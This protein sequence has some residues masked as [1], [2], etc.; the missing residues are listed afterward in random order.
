MAAAPNIAALVITLLR[1]IPLC[2]FLMGDNLGGGVV[3]VGGGN[4]QPSIY[5]ISTPAGLYSSYTSG[6]LSSVP[7]GSTSW[8]HLVLRA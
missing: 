1:S 5:T 2:K 8:G 4:H 7:I 6:L 3:G